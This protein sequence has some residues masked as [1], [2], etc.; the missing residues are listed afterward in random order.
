MSDIAKPELD[1]SFFDR[2]CAPETNNKM[3]IKPK[4]YN[5]SHRKKVQIKKY[6]KQFNAIWDNKKITE[7]LIKKQTDLLMYG[8]TIVTEDEVRETL[9]FEQP[10]EQE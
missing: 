7:L 4:S 5:A 8:E 10:D 3:K 2:L 6:A 1:F 9:R